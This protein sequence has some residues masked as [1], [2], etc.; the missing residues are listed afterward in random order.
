MFGLGLALGI[1][2]SRQINFEIAKTVV[3]DPVTPPMSSRQRHHDEE[4]GQWQRIQK[5][6]LQTNN[7]LGK[8]VEIP[9][10]STITQTSP[11]LGRSTV[12][13]CTSD[14]WGNL[15]RDFRIS[16]RYS[17]TFPGSTQSLRAPWAVDFKKIKNW[18]EQNNN[19][20]LDRMK[21]SS[22]EELTRV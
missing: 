11:Q 1:E 14:F 5:L 13:K 22:C 9:T 6:K 3:T 12:V 19:S 20:I 15:P 16:H 10:C 21:M 8:K 7:R 18:I 2:I 4:N 17:D